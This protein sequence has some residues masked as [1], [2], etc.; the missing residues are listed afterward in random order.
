M[1]DV[2]LLLGWFFGEKFFGIAYGIDFL[3]LWTRF[4]DL[5][6]ATGDANPDSRMQ[7]EW[8]RTE[9]PNP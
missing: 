3:Q 5:H 6:P 4:N 9:S 8:C 2:G 7:V 1:A